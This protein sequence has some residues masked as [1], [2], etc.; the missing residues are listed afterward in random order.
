MTGA[1]H[2]RF[3]YSA[4][5]VG[6]VAP[7]GRIPISRAN[8]HAR[9]WRLRTLTTPAPP[10]ELWAQDLWDAVLGAH[11]ADRVA[12]RNRAEDRWTRAID[13]DLPVSEPDRWTPRAR[14]TLTNLLEISTGDRWTLSFRRS[15]SSEPF[16]NPRFDEE[17][18]TTVTEVALFSGGLDST[19]YAADLARR[20]ADALLVTFTRPRLSPIQDHVLAAVAQ[21]TT[22]RGIRRID[23]IPM[24]P[25]P[26]P[27]AKAMAEERR[28][29]RSSRSRGLLFTTTAVY[30]AAAYHADRVAVPENGQLAINPPLSPSRW[31]SCSTRSVHPWILHQ[32]NSLI[33]ELGGRVEVVNPLLGMTKGEVCFMASATGLSDQVLFSTISCGKPPFFRD[34]RHAQHCGLCVACLMRRSGLLAARGYDAT[35][36]QEPIPAAASK[37]RSVDIAAL[38][39]WVAVGFRLSDLIADLPLPADADVRAM[40]DTLVRGR[41]ELVRL[42]SSFAADPPEAL[43]SLAA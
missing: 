37:I 25:R 36:Y 33:A 24:D 17:A 20:G 16:A 26:H 34:T 12:P 4:T 3:H 6:A 31:S 11:I 22:G 28:L 1:G 8:L 40:A 9:N 13:L 29:E 7:G 14:E 42:L 41:A 5:P 32:L 15:R 27:H 35:D 18:A 21:L 30:I 43:V 10:P 39:R 38:A 19:A 23:P 2:Y